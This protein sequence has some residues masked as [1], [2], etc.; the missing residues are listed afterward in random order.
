[1][2]DHEA[3]TNPIVIMPDTHAGKGSVIGFTMKLTDKVIPNIVGVDVGCGMLG[4]KIE[5]PQLPDLASLD[6]A[7]RNAIPMGFNVHPKADKLAWGQTGMLLAAKTSATIGVFR[8]GLDK[9]FGKSP[10]PPVLT[11]GSIL[12]KCD[13]IG[14]GGNRMI[15]SLGSLGGGNH[16]IEIGECKDSAKSYWVIIHSGSRQFGQK[17]CLYWQKLASEVPDAARKE[18]KQEVFKIREETKDNTLIPDKI[19]AAKKKF[20]LNKK[21]ADLD[22]LTGEDAFGY[23]YDMCLAQT[24]AWMNRK[25]MMNRICHILEAT[26]YTALEEVETVHNYIDPLDLTIRKGAVRSY[27]GQKLIIPF[28]MADGTLICEGKSNP[29]WLNTAPHGCGRRMSRTKA[30][31]TLDIK[32]AEERMKGI[33]TSCIPLDEAPDAYKPAKVI[34]E[35]IGPTARIIER[36]KPIINIK[37]G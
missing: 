8:N 22:F 13:Q 33:Y 1:M 27:E 20:G 30:K 26:G 4:M 21:P 14:M 15:Q 7:I 11:S 9:T 2:T 6:K 3:F 32:R 35:A 36:V 24:Y 17:I 12:E 28:N 16:F 18:F 19:K 29:D 10:D 25:L 34:E 5:L 31:K 37:A 23:L